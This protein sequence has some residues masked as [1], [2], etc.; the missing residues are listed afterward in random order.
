MKT[1]TLSRKGERP[2]TLN[3]ERQNHKFH[4]ASTTKQWRA[5]YTM[6]ARAAKI[7][8]LHA[9]A[10]VAI[11]HHVNRRSPQDV[12]ACVPAVKAA[13]DGLVDAGVIPNDT[14]V[15]F[16]ALTFLPPVIDGWDG[17]ELRIMEVTADQSEDR[18]G[19]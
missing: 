1:W 12:G 7:P 16:K 14:S 10:V 4:R 2:P 15:Y 5:D 8:L 17:L 9:I 18:A 19:G 3:I 13:V 6:L 11:P